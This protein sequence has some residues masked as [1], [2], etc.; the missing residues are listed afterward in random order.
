MITHYGFNDRD[1]IQLFQSVLYKRNTQSGAKYDERLSTRQLGRNWGG[2]VY[3]SD[4]KKLLVMTDTDDGSGGTPADCKISWATFND[5]LRAHRPDDYIVLKS[6]INVDPEYNQFY[7]F[8]NDVYSI[9]IFS[10]DPE[11]I[12]SVKRGLPQVTKDIDVFFSGGRKFDHLNPYAWPKNR[13]PKMWWPGASVRGYKKLQEIKD[14]HPHI[15]IQIFDG[16][17]DASKFYG[18][19]NRSKICIDLPGIGL[20]S[21]KFYEYMVL[22]KCV[23]ALQQQH[24]PWECVPDVH[25]ASLGYDLDFCR[26]EEKIIQLHENR[27]MVEEIESNVR[28]I[29]SQLT[30]D[31][32]IVR[33]ENIINEKVASM[34]LGSLFLNA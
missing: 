6:Q 28:N 11:K 9:G 2:F 30:L 31:S 21:R 3:E 1:H 13:D 18:L 27:Q 34:K 23:V 4:G 26:L 17:L 19:I 8:K 12:F 32:M 10:N 24:T 15:N 16:I 20:S 33:I 29:T 7:P 5:V 22:G 14:R 25:Y